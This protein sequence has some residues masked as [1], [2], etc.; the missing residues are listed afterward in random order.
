MSEPLG[1]DDADAVLRRA[2]ELGVPGPDA[3]RGVGRDALAAAASEVGI[4]AGAVE[5]A[6][7]EHDAGILRTRP[8][9]GGLLGASRVVEVRT[10]PVPRAD[11]HA[12]VVTWFRKQLLI[13]DERRGDTEVYRPRDDLGAK[14][15]RKVDKRTGRKLR[16]GELDAVVL[17]T[18]SVDDDSSVV[19]LEAVFDSLRSGLRSGVVVLPT[20]TIPVL[21]VAAGWLTGEVAFAIGGLPLAGVIG[22]LG[23][24]TGRK[25]LEDQ[26]DSARRTLRGVLDDLEGV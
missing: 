25:T 18:A 24:Y 14:I 21:G 19:R 5:L 3:D 2:A 20:V 15:R 6:L 16:L 7:A 12:R 4:D 22:G 23:T 11:A 10:V 8:S 9:R 17:S 1:P 26:R 13:R